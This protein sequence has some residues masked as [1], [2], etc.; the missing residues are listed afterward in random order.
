MLSQVLRPQVSAARL[1]MKISTFYNHISRAILPPTIK[2][3]PRAVGHPSHE[4]DAI[5]SA[6]IA[7]KSESEIKALVVSLTA[8]RQNA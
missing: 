3:G 5:I 8:A 2:F 6:R 7:G 4:I 1:G